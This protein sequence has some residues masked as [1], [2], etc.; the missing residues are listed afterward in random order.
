MIAG[1]FPDEIEDED[2]AISELFDDVIE[3]Y[4]L[5]SSPSTKLQVIQGYNQLRANDLTGNTREAI[6]IFAATEE[7]E[8]QTEAHHSCKNNN[9]NE[10][11]IQ[12]R[13]M[14]NKRSKTEIKQKLAHYAKVMKF[15][16]ENS[17]S[18]CLSNYKQI[19]DNN[20]HIV[21]P[22]CGHP[23]CCACADKIMRSK[24]KECP[25]CRGNVTA[26]S[27]NIMKFNADLEIDNQDQR[28]FL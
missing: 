2:E 15:F 14:T 10:S 6:E 9:D 12:T 17:C 24:K 13:S 16:E 22:S 11:T 19:V 4:G 23:L 25:R 27:F 1:N 26:D 3:D 8:R 5:I 20:L 7:Q 28:V 21:N 18:V